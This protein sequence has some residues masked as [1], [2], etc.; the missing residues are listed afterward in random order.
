MKIQKN[1]FS[2]FLA[3]FFCSMLTAQRFQPAMMGYSH[4]KTS[5]LTLDNGKEVKGT[6]KD[7]DWKKGLIEEVKLKDASDKK[8]KIKPEQIDFMYLPPS[9]LAK[10]S[11]SLEFMGNVDNWQNDDLDNDILQKGYVYMEKSEVRIKKKTRTLMMQLV[12]PTFSSKIK[13]YDDPLAK[14]AMGVGVGGVTVAGGGE[15]SYFIKKKG[16]KVAFKVEK[17]NYKEEFRMIFGDCKEFMQKNKD[18]RWSD[19]QQ[20]VFDYSQ[21]CK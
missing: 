12:N 13:V 16:E 20:H 9:G 21:A 8:V 17:K 18:P 10:V 2:L 5:Y 15:K 4:K 19:F 6:I 1:I 11:A 3:L 14:E 7:L